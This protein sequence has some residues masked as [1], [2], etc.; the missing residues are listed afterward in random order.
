M[1][2][3]NNFYEIGLRLVKEKKFREAMPFFRKCLI[4]NPGNEKAYY[5]LLMDAALTKQYKYFYEL[6]MKLKDFGEPRITS[7]VNYYLFLFKFF[8]NESTDINIKLEDML[9][10]PEESERNLI[11]ENVYKRSFKAAS[12][13]LHERFIAGKDDNNEETLLESKLIQLAKYSYQA[14]KEKWQ[15]LIAVKYYNKLLFLLTKRAKL[16]INSNQEE[17]LKKLAEIYEKLS[18]GKTLIINQDVKG[19]LYQLIDGGNYTGA[20]KAIEEN[21]K[22]DVD[23]LLGTI[24]FDICYLNERLKKQELVNNE[25][26]KENKY[27]EDIANFHRN[28][29]SQR[30]VRILGKNVGQRTLDQLHAY[31]DEDNKVKTISII[32]ESNNQRYVVINKR[33]NSSDKGDLNK[34]NELFNKEKYYLAIGEYI[35][36]IETTDDYPD[37]VYYNL[38]RAL[39]NTRDVKRALIYCRL[40]FNTEKDIN[41]QSELIELAK[42]LKSAKDKEDLHYEDR[43]IN[44]SS[45][46][47]TGNPID[48]GVINDYI[49][50]SQL[51]VTTAGYE[52]GLSE[53]DIN[54]VKLIY[55]RE[56]YK[57]HAEQIADLFIKSVIK[58]KNRSSEVNSLLDK[59]N[60]AKSLYKKHP[61]TNDYN[62]PFNIKPEGKKM[63]NL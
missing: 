63:Y 8:S 41:K 3:S 53:D 22:V 47:E 38:T 43:K 25:L 24:L 57:A 16:K 37:Y 26:K 11:R 59:I 5:Q 21:R 51:D 15:E 13:M 58:S 39:I 45:E 55:A 30:G 54:I 62:I 50:A 49:I 40:A 56:Y 42:Q 44:F 33:Y 1:G 34:A 46:E 19:D 27:Q 4:V 52:L 28:L 48:F 32:D 2:E 60:K 14:G 6:C 23:G 61:A 20:L 10:E 9:L 29:L 18:K 31:D 7:N 17:R 35:K 36:I 12:D